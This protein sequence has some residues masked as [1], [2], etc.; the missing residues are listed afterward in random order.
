M[1][2][3][4][5]FLDFIGGPQKSDDP[6]RV[7]G[8]DLYN[9]MK[10]CSYNRSISGKNLITLPTQHLFLMMH[11]IYIAGET[12]EPIKCIKSERIKMFLKTVC[13]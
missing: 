10:I 12:T 13:S 7:S 4:H 1:S 8:Y 2:F 5:I 9:L 3:S 11:S 6:L